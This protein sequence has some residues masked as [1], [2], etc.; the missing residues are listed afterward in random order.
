MPTPSNH[1]SRPS[2]DTLKGIIIDT[3]EE[4]PQNHTTAK[5][6]VGLLLSMNSPTAHLIHTD[7]ALSRDEHRCV[8]TKKIDVASFEDI[9]ELTQRVMSD[10]SLSTVSTQ[11]AHIFS[12]STNSKIEPGSDKVWLPFHFFFLNKQLSMYSG[13]MLPLFGP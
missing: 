13:S 11:C 4:A 7:Q 9:P 8:V 2:F 12:E 3:L 5:R 6:R 10:P 1:A